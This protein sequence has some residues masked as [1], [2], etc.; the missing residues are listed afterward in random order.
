MRQTLAVFLVAAAAA[1]GQGGPALATRPGGD[2]IGRVGE[3][4]IRFQ[5]FAGVTGVYDTGAVPLSL[6]PNG[7]LPSASAYGVET[8]AG[9]TLGD[10]FKGGDFTL[11]YVG[12]YRKYDQVNYIGG[13]DQTIGMRYA[14]RLNKRW[15]LVSAASGGTNSRN[16][17]F[18]AYSAPITGELAPRPQTEVFDSRSYFGDVSTRLTFLINNRWS[19]SFSGEGVVTQRQ[20]SRLTGFIGGLAQ[21]DIAYRLSRRETVSIGYVYNNVGYQRQFGS[22]AVNGILGA[23]SRQFGRRYTLQLTGGMLRAETKGQRSQQID[24]ILAAILGRTETTVIAYNINYIPSYG[25]GFIA[26]FKQAEYH[27]EGAQTAN[28]GGNGVYLASRQRNVS[29]GVR[30]ISRDRVSYY[31]TAGYYQTSALSQALVPLSNYNVFAGA[32]CKLRGNFFLNASYSFR[33]YA[34]ESSLLQRDSNRVTV[35]VS[36][37]LTRFPFIAR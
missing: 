26:R 11:N 14:K 22:A 27:L 35:G 28:P 29:G 20:D 34:A 2:A 4:L 12:A 37:S 13:V 9:V 19:A 18:V 17:G 36:Y 31:A 5:A 32:D 25:A 3:T 24:P 21:G 1:Y 16:S 6:D 23:Y 8:S 30:Y 33:G 7:K 15:E 10:T